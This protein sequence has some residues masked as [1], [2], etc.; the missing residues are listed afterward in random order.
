MVSAGGFNRGP[1]CLPVVLGRTSGLVRHQRRPASFP[2]RAPTRCPTPAQD[3]EEVERTGAHPAGVPRADGRAAGA[4]CPDADLRPRP[5]PVETPSSFAV[6]A[7]E[8][9][10]M[11]PVPCSAPVAGSDLVEK[12]NGLRGSITLPAMGGREPT[13]VPRIPPT[14][15]PGELR[16]YAGGQ[17]S[18]WRVARGE[19]ATQDTR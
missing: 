8:N 13:V 17:R 2:R 16:Y 14:Y 1:Y 4:A 12:I 7:T 11:V 3:Q 5:V 19:R 15:S 9:L 18:G 6:S 10:F